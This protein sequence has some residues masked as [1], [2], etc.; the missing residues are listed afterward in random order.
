MSFT[1]KA[2]TPPTRAPPESSST[3][4][5]DLGSGPTNLVNDE[6]EMNRRNSTVQ[7][8]ARK[9]TGESSVN[10]N[11]DRGFLIDND[12]ESALNPRTWAKAIAKLASDN[13]Q[14]FRQTGVCFQN[15]GVYGYGSTTDFQKD[16]AN[17]WLALPNMIRRVFMKTA[18]Q[19]RIDILQSFEGVIRPG[20][21]C[22]ILGPPGSGCST[23]LKTLSGDTNGIHVNKDSYFNY[24][25]LSPQELHSAH[26]GDAIYTAEV[27]VHFPHLTVGETLEFASHA[28]CQRNLPNGIDRDQ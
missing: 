16:V 14:N 22:V 24:Q 7:N 4:F 13:G 2:S 28:R 6:L 20:E 5:E 10:F 8:L 18:G 12:P 25:G 3:F 15:L 1:S 11:N 19:R 26:K 23:F 21:M 9:Y 27:D 17:I